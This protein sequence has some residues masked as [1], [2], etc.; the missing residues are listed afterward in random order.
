MTSFFEHQRSSF[1]R[2]YLRNL[3][4]LASSDGI[5]DDNEKRILF[6][7]G[8]KRGLKEWQVEEL[9][10]DTSEFEMFI[11]ESFGNRMNLLFDLMQ[12]IY[13][14]GKV[15]GSEITF[16]HKTLSS[17]NLP[18]ETLVELIQVFKNGTLTP[19]E[20][21]DF[22]EALMPGEPPPV[23]GIGATITQDSSL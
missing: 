12:I 1:K 4:L 17:F 18:P 13:A 14:D 6:A 19:A 9:L 21:R 10:Q 16:A 5:L 2:S 8:K 15:D 22:T 7:I 20:W 11:P 23:N 3:I